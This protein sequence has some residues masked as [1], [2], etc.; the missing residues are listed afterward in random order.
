M[1]LPNSISLV[2]ILL[3]PIILILMLVNWDQAI[4]SGS[5]QLQVAWLLA[6]IFFIVAV[7][8]DYLDGY[9]ARKLKQV[10]TFGKFFDSIADKLLTNSVLIVMSYFGIVPIWMTLIL[11]MRDFLIDAL[12]QILAS[13]QVIMAA[14]WYGK[15]KAAFQM[16]GM[17]ILFFVSYKNFGGSTV[18]NGT[19]DQYGYINQ[20]IFIPM[21]LTTILSLY[22]AG[23]YF[24]LNY[25]HLMDSQSN[26]PVKIK[27]SKKVKK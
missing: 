25:P 26:K 7:L 5:Y 6:G 11:I 17:S 10:T 3:I 21:Y 27:K 9:L 22:S 20:L 8:S 12:R 15:W 18:G 14:N 19:Y 2:R 24:Y 4:V 1:N 13:R 23:V 16:G